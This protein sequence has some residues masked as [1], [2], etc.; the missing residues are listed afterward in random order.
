MKKKLNDEYEGLILKELAE[1]FAEEDEEMY[2]TLRNDKTIVNPNQ[3]ELDKKMLAMIKK[4]ER[5]VNTK[6]QLRIIK[7]IVL[8]AAVFIGVLSACF[9]VMFSTVEAFKVAVLN[10][11][12]EQNEK[13]S[14]LSLSKNDNMEVPL[15]LNG[16]YYP[17]YMLEGYEIKKTFISDI[18]V[19]ISYENQNDQV[20]NYSCFGKGVKTGIDT[21]NR[22]ETS[23][24]INGL[25]GN[26]YSKDGHRILV[27]KSDEYI[28]VVDG[29]TTQEEI[30][31]IGESI[32][33]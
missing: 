33:K 7:K 21:E 32:K 5:K 22:M 3:E 31:K 9:V 14:I 26:I 23:V 11:V 30:I 24:D 16:K 20:I 18:R 4:Y 2:Q 29:F 12:I 19:E 25:E 10:F 28:F 8:R 27:F 13:F 1:L 6:N 17:H 15:E